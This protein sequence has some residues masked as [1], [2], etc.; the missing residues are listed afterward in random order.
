MA[1]SWPPY[2]SRLDLKLGAPVGSS[3][4]EEALAYGLA[5]A[6]SPMET[7]LSLCLLRKQ[8]RWTQAELRCLALG[9]ARLLP[10]SASVRSMA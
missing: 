9:L 10:E 6:R 2:C 4:R 3:R 7:A 1:G 8:S 5:L